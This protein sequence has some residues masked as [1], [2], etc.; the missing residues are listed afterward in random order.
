MGGQR[1]PDTTPIHAAHTPTQP[2]PLPKNTTPGVYDG[3]GG[4]EVAEFAQENLHR[5][6]L[7]AL[8]E[9]VAAG[10]QADALSTSQASAL[11]S[12]SAFATCLSA[13]D[14]VESECGGGDGDGGSSSAAPEDSGSCGSPPSSARAPP[15]PMLRRQQQ[16]QQQNQNH[17]QQAAPAAADASTSYGGPPSPSASSLAT[18]ERRS[19]AVGRALR[20]AFMRTDRDLAG[21]EVGELVG[22]TALVAVVGGGEVHLAHCGD[23]RAVLCRKGA[24][25]LLTCDHKPNRKD[26][27][28]SVGAQRGWGGSVA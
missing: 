3:H 9:Y 5:H 2:H 10:S 8:S 1:H 22:S 27:A 28:V 16:Q 18:S 23:S 6:F 13:L 14:A 19:E 24:A 20:Q 17:Q 7:G 12:G 15:T 26:E 11:S 4:K 25:I 21:T